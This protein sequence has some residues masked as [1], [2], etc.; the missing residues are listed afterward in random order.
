MVKRAAVGAM[1]ISKTG[2]NRGFT[3]LELL[4]AMAIM[5]VMTGVVAATITPTLADARLRAGS[6]TVIAA[7]R[8]ARS[9][10][11]SHQTEAAVLFNLEQRTLSVQAL[12]PDEDD[13]T[14]RSW[15]SV[16]D[17]AGRQRTL[18]NGISIQEVR[19]AETDGETH[20]PAVHFSSLGQGEDVRITVTDGQ[21]E[22]VLQVDAVTGRCSFAEDE[23]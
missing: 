13:A 6:R 1:R 18:P 9:Y 14:T 16:T 10:A 12:R 15:Q 4:V 7:L 21:H 23:P 19:G 8:Y 11:V 3:L 22:R 20:E 2:S 5:V 17:Q